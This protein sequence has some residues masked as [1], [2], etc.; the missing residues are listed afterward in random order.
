[1]PAAGGGRRAE[2]VEAAFQLV[3]SSGLEGLRLRQVAEAVGIDHS[4]LHHH[5]ATKQDLISAVAEYTTRQFW[6]TMPAVPADPAAQLRG[7]LTALRTLITERPELFLVTAE[8]DLRARRDGNV[9]ALLHR[10]EDGWRARLRD[11]VADGTAARAWSPGVDD[12]A[13]ELIIAVVKGARLAPGTAAAVFAQLE[14]LITAHP[15]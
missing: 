6:S 5:F 7:H 1:M 10:F 11:L 9:Q 4:T 15:G 12:D 3:A 13:V 14:R 8:L 2:L